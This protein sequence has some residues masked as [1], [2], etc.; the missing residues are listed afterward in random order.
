MATFKL[1]KYVI[2]G[3]GSGI[4]AA[5]WWVAKDKDFKKIIDKTERDP[6]AL[7]EW[8]SMLPKLPEDGGKGYYKNLKELYVKVQIHVGRTSSGPFITGPFTQRSLPIVITEQDKE[9]I[10]TNTD[11]IGMNLPD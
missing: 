4:D 9:D 6:S 11:E 8:S 1:S 7:T 3:S 2:I 5:S 10:V